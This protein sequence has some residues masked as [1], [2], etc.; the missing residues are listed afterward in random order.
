VIAWKLAS[1]FGSFYTEKRLLA[2]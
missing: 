2:A 1:N